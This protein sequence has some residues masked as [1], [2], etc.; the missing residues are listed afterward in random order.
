MH[1]VWAGVVVHEIESIA[2]RDKVSSKLVRRE[3]ATGSKAISTNLDHPEI[4]PTVVSSQSLGMVTVNI[5]STTVS[6]G[7]NVET[8][9][10]ITA[11]ST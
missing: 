2:I 7:S 10:P 4:E 8:S 6:S 9:E 11:L 1:D 5:D 3:I